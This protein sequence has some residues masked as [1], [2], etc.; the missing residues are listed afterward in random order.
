MSL[1]EFVRFLIIRPNR[2]VASERKM[3]FSFLPES[4]FPLR[5]DELLV[6]G[7]LSCSKVYSLISPTPGS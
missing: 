2:S 5:V 4:V 3:S 6:F 7:A 1:R